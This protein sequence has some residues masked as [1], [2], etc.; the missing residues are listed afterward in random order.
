[1]DFRKINYSE[2][3]KNICPNHLN[4]LNQKNKS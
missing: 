1:M 3:E 4:M 2:F